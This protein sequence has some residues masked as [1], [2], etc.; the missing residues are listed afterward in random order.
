M[1]FIAV[2]FIK[3]KNWKYPVF[4]L[5]RE[6]FNGYIYPFLSIY[7]YPYLYIPVSYRH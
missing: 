3:A 1:M 4:P 6:I 2:L 7:K 5:R